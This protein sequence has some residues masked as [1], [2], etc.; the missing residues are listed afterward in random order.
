MMMNEPQNARNRRACNRRAPRSKKHAS[1]TPMNT[2]QSRE[3]HTATHR[4]TPQNTEECAKRHKT[5]KEHST[6]SK[7][8]IVLESL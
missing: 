7:M 4:H 2:E 8:K 3:T 1:I 6:Q 5:P